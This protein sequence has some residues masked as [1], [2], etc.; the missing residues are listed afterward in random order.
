MDEEFHHHVKYKNQILK[1]AAEVKPVVAKP[2][3]IK[4]VRKHKKKSR[5]PAKDNADISPEDRDKE[6]FE[7]PEQ[8]EPELEQEGE[9][10]DTASVPISKPEGNVQHDS[11]LEGNGSSNRRFCNR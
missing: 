6:E 3:S 11:Q 8:P 7:Q 5:K 10:E 9:G 2:A 4:P 1:K